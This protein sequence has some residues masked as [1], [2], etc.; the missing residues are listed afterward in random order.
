MKKNGAN[1]KFSKSQQGKADLKPIVAIFN[2]LARR[3]DRL[4]QK[5]DFLRKDTAR[6]FKKSD[7]FRKETAEQFKASRKETDAQFKAS[8]K[9]TDAQF[10]ASRK[11]T[12]AQFKAS[13][14]ETDAQFKASRKEMKQEI[15][16]V[17]E[18]VMKY[19]FA[20]RDE[21]RIIADEHARTLT[22]NYTTMDRMAKDYSRWLI[23]KQ[24][25]DVEL[26]R[27]SREINE[28]AE[29]D[30]QKDMLL[31]DLQKRV[32]ALEN[33]KNGNTATLHPEPQLEE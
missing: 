15:K 3:M 26:E 5:M 6:E 22:K 13:R 19:H 27:H 33:T 30:T 21:N 24:Y 10:K 8:R 20:A 23:E 32:A 7:S 16:S 14:K 31:H 11:E 12:D 18:D 1:R 9:E 28:L 2:K 29:K 17:R 25:N 4:D